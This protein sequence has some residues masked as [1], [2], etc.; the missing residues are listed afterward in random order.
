MADGVAVGEGGG[1]GEL[2]GGRAGVCARSSHGRPS[3][4]AVRKRKEAHRNMMARDLS[5]LCG[6]GN[7]PAIMR[8]LKFDLGNSFIGALPRFTDRR[9]YGGHGQHPST[10]GDY[11]AVIE[12]RSGVENE[13]ILEGRA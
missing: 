11:F 13:D 8:T 3:T 9:T 1:G 5:S 12:S 6:K 10:R 2:A 7:I 4:S